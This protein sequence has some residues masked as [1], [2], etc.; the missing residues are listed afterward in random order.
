MNTSEIQNILRRNNASKLNFGGV[1]ALN[2]LPKIAK[3]K[4]YIINLDKSYENGSHW[5]AIYFDK[6]G[7]GEYFDSFGLPPFLP[8]LKDFLNRNCKMW[9]YNSKR[10]QSK[11]T[12]VCGQ[13]CIYF[14][15]K[16]FNKKKIKDIV[17]EF[18]M[19]YDKNDM[20]VFNAIKNIKKNI[21]YKFK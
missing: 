14:L 8:E 21:N 4:A 16:R 5:V 20:K 12:L 1:Y 13:Y 3:N 11:D 7:R 6:N 9:L 15:I 2:E 17:N 10:L 18:S 19:S